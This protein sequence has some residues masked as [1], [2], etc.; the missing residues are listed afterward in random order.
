MLFVM[1]TKFVFHGCYFERS[2]VEP[3]SPTA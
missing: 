2:D 1:T 3:T